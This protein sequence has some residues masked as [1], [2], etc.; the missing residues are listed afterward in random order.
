[1]YRAFFVKAFL[2][3][4][5]LVSVFLFLCGER[6]VSA[7]SIGLISSTK[8]FGLNVNTVSADGNAYNSYSLYADFYGL[9]NRRTDEPGILF[10]YSRNRILYSKDL[11][12]AGLL[13]Y[14][15]PG[16]SFGYTHDYERGMD[17]PLNHNGGL[18]LALCGSAGFRFHFTRGI[19]FDL[20]WTVQAGVHIR[21]D[22]VLE[23]LD[24]SWYQNG[25]LQAWTPSL[26]IMYS[27]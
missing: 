14:I 12:E 13:F 19:C 11:D 16:V 18:T 10:H 9:L 6:I 1:M 26:T 3:Y 15:G 7:R 2:K 23:S 27:F 17:Q 4:L 20:G 24:L 21:N 22:E 8:G 5:L 25:I